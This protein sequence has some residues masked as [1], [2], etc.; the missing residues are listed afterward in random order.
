[1]LVA[2]PQ[3]RSNRLT[4]VIFGRFLAIPALACFCLSGCGSTATV[5]TQTPTQGS[6]VASDPSGTDNESI[7]PSGTS[8]K[9]TVAFTM[10]PVYCCNPRSMVFEAQVESYSN[11]KE[12]V[13]RWDFGDGRTASGVSV[14][15]T[16]GWPGKYVVSLHADLPNDS[17][18]TSEQELTLPGET[19][20]PENTDN[21]DAGEPTGPMPPDDSVVD[22]DTTPPG[23]TADE[24][25]T[26]G[27]PT[28]GTT[29]PSGV[30]QNA[31]AQVMAGQV[32][33]ADASWWG[34]DPVD[35]TNAIQSAIN[36]GAK[37]VIIPNMG[38]DWIV[39]PL[40]LVSNQEIVFA[41]G[42]V[43]TAKSGAFR[44]MYDC[45]LSASR[46]SNV[47]LRGTN[48]ILQMRKADYMSS[49]YSVSEWRHVLSMEGVNNVQVSGLSFQSSG[50]DGLIISA[51]DDALHLASRNV[52]IQNCDFYNNYR[53][54]ISVLSAENL[55]IDNCTIRGTI[56]TAPQAAIDLE[57][58]D[59]KDVLIN[60]QI[61]NCKAIGNA[62][63][64][65][66]ANLAQ[67]VS[68]SRPISVSVV[69]H[70]V[71]GSRQP[72]MRVL[73]AK[74]GQPGGHLDFRNC[75]AEGT[76][77]SGLGIKWNM[78]SAFEVTFDHCEW[79]NNARFIE[80]A[81]IDMEFM[82]SGTA[83]SPG[84]I[85]FVDCVV[86]DQKARDTVQIADDQLISGTPDVT[87]TIY[88]TN[89]MI[90]S[91]IPSSGWLLPD[92]N[93]QMTPGS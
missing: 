40:F 12:I 6:D 14:E 59:P 89:P 80:D 17:T 42:V 47:K 10:T 20:P 3:R 54:G 21:P 74:N 7:S 66:M 29:D 65:F 85:R 22:G 76:E 78:S 53:Q 82:G 52:L 92:L 30:N 26:D 49:N 18:L 2:A 25:P 61:T 72:A 45:L 31:I 15:H 93:V 77:Y 83:T 84:G 63:S 86:T 33:T 27:D 50:G 38:S 4:R 24:D 62:G 73:V 37:T 9:P 55:T 91:P 44:G 60:V 51:Y 69:N 46:V 8:S 56:G 36:S 75:I 88:V 23:D 32:T 71:Q 19:I 48:A 39:R 81:P 58:D 28:D 1:M 70:L 87:G 67:M 11:V 79:R 57:P 68:T 43:L 16:Y 64:G 90:N 35:S 5:P 34:F 41:D 13:F